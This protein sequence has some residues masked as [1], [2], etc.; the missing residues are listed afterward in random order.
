MCL[1]IQSIVDTIVVSSIKAEPVW[2]EA[3]SP[4]PFLVIVHIKDSVVEPWG[5]RERSVRSCAHFIPV[6]AECR[7]LDGNGE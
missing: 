3:S 5:T 4:G 1:P 7:E 6:C 2:L